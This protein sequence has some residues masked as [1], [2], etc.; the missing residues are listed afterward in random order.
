[1]LST[2]AAA[3]LNL[4]SL[5]RKSKKVIGHRQKGQGSRSNGSRERESYYVVCSRVE[6]E[7][8]RRRRESF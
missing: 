6:R 1:M 3:A 5:H 8:E 4:N 7:G 2:Y